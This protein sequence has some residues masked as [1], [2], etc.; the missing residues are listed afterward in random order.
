MPRR[1][2]GALRAEPA[3]HPAGPDEL[4]I[5][6]HRVSLRT[7]LAIGRVERCSHDYFIF[8]GVTRLALGRYRAFLRPL[9]RRPRYPAEYGCGC[10][11]SRLDDVRHA[12]LILTRVLELLPARERGEF[13]RLL[14]PLDD[15]YRRCTLPDPF[16]D[17]RPWRG[18]FWWYRRLGAEL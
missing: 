10:R 18:A 14:R 6:M 7:S 11:R 17:R 8:P 5:R 1:R 13:G 4:P 9:G 12:R 2:P 16:A 15:R 3:I